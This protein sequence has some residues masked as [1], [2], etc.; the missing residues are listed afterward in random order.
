[1]RTIR[2]PGDVISRMLTQPI[3]GRAML[4]PVQ[5]DWPELRLTEAQMMANA[6]WASEP[7]RT[8]PRPFPDPSIF[9]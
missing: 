2:I 9:E 3:Q 5:V 6:V 1:M 4:F 8:T 7:H